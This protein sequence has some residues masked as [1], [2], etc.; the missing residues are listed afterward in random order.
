MLLTTYYTYAYSDNLKRY[1]L[2]EPT[3][4]EFW[5][6]QFYQTLCFLNKEL[7]I[8]TVRT[9]LKTEEQRST[10]SLTE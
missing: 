1:K 5:Q 2:I 4:T 8:V 3:I 7:A 6:Y 9:T 10:K